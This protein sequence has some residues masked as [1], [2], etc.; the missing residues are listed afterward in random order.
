MKLLPH[1][2]RLTLLS[3]TVPT[4]FF[5][6]HLLPRRP[7]MGEALREME[8]GLVS[9]ASRTRAR[10]VTLMMACR[11]GRMA[12]PRRF[13]LW[14]GANRPRGVRRRRLVPRGIW[15]PQRD[16]HDAGDEGAIMRVYTARL[17]AFKQRHP[18][19]RLRKRPRRRVKSCS[20]CHIVVV[21]AVPSFSIGSVEQA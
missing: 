10:R 13:A 4:G 5:T 8:R 16:A 12:R 1:T 19:C 20:R 9:L 11:G 21:P 14:R 15:Q 3:S 17:D 18:C 6:T 2:S 7:S